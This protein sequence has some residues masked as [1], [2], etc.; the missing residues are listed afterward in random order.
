VRGRCAIV[1]QHPD[2]FEGTIAENVARGRPGATAAEIEAASRRAHAHEFV[3]ALPD[4][5]A[6]RL[7]ARGAGLSGGQRQRIALARAVLRDP[8][9]L[10]LDEPT[11]ALDRESEEALKTAIADFLPGRTVFVIAHRPETVMRADLVLVLRDGSAEAFGTP[12]AVAA[13]SETYRRLLSRGF[14]DDGAGRDPA[15]TFEAVNETEPDAASG[16]T[17]P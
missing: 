4:G 14:G 2:L 15:T 11:S 8:R 9:V 10:L 12:D 16:A 5:Y 17:L 6:T 7:G 3:A 1:H 13:R